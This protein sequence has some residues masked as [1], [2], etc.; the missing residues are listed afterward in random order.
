MHRQSLIRT[1]LALMMLLVASA[2]AFAQATGGAVKGR[3][4]DQNGAAIQNATVTLKNESTSQTLTAQS[5]DNGAFN[6]PNTLPGEYTITVEGQGFEALTQKVRVL[7]NQ[8]STSRSCAASGRR[9]QHG[10]HYFGRRRPR[11]D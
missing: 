6:F 2:A 9:Q 8:E 10:G 3:A 4:V 5:S 11:A 1:L 7:L